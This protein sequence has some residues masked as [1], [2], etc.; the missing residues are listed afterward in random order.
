MNNH[1]EYATLT[2]LFSKI[3]VQFYN[4][5]VFILFHTQFSFDILRIYNNPVMQVLLAK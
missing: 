1:I 2:R 3:Q 4:H 5:L